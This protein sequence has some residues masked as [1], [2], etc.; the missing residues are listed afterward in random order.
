MYMGNTAN[1]KIEK[2]VET[3]VELNQVEVMNGSKK[4]ESKLV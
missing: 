1:D 2:Q 3:Y 4:H